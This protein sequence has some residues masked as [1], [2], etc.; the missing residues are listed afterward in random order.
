MRRE[1]AEATAKLRA[2]VFDRS[3]GWCECG[4]GEQISEATGEMDHFFGRAKV[5]QAISNCWALTR[6]CHAGKTSSRTSAKHWLECFVRHAVA[7]GYWPEV[8]RAADRLA[9][10]AAK[11]LM[12]HGL[13]R[14]AESIGR[15]ADALERRTR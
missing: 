3:N 4:C 5:P 14:T 15:S 12:K 7:H 1:T 8:N 10:L 6:Q 13:R 2:A 9:V 11:E